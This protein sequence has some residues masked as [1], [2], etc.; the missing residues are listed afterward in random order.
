[1]P[2]K[3]KNPEVENEEV[4]DDAVETE[5]ADNDDQ[6]ADSDGEEN[7]KASDEDK[8]KD[9]EEEEVDEESVMK[10]TVFLG[11]IKYYISKQEI[12]DFFK[13]VGEIESIRIISKRGYAFVQFTEPEAVEEA[14]KLDNKM[15]NG[16]A[17]H[18]ER[19]KTMKSKRVREN[20]EE[21]GGK[22]P[23]LDKRRPRGKRNHRNRPGQFVKAK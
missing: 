17:V 14:M 11:H 7:E 21:H 6:Q 1:M 13:G 10:R 18:V 3:R 23:R 22:K 9:A 16:K 12:S 4:D 2:T 5:E 20:S 15:L 19:V 8:T